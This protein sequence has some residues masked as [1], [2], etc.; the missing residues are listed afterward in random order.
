MTN[1]V[2]PM[3]GAGSRFT[4]AGY[5]VPKPL[6]DVN[7]MPMVQKAIWGSG[8]GG[9]VIYVV[10]AEHNAQYNLSELLPTFTPN[11]DVIIVEVDGVT[12]G[13]AVTVLAAK[14]YIDNDDILIICDSDSVVSWTPNEFMAS[15][16]EARNLDGAIAVFPAEGDRWSYVALDEDNLV[17]EVAEKDQISDLACAG[18]YYWREGA[19][20]VKYAEKMISEDKRVNGE[21]Y[22][23]PVYNE[24]IE[25]TRSIGT[26]EVDSVLHLGTPEDLEAYLATVNSS[27]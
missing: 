11:L 18:V 24:A 25:D 16:G 19:E 3:A 14:E 1:V 8:I 13:A 20:F 26:Y 7:G 17:T 10:Q 6:I 5:D 12:E 23:A 15:V 9:R 2:I 4:D 22:I 27:I 21:F